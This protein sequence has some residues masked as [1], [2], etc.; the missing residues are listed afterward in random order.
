MSFNLVISDLLYV[1]MPDVNAYQPEDLKTAKRGWHEV[2]ILE[3][4]EK[5]KVYKPLATFFEKSSQEVLSIRWDG[6]LVSLVH[7][8]PKDL[9]PNLERSLIN[10]YLNGEKLNLV[11]ARSKLRIVNGVELQH[12]QLR[13]P[14]IMGGKVEVNDSRDP[15]L[16]TYEFRLREKQDFPRVINCSSR[17]GFEFTIPN[18]SF[19]QDPKHQVTLR[20]KNKLLEF[21]STFDFSFDVSNVIPKRYKLFLDGEE[22]YLGL[23]VEQRSEGTKVS[24]LATLPVLPGQHLEIHDLYKQKSSCIQLIK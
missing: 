19:D 23:K 20:V 17:S 16:N 7:L 3:P 18:S 2:H 9:Y 12:W 1:C 22:V 15:F 11:N 21:S 10:C 14:G 13:F 24:W 5:L 4:S 8:L 6:H